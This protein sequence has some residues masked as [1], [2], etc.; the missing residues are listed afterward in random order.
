MS[1]EEIIIEVRKVI[2]AEV[3]YLKSVY[4]GQRASNYKANFPCVFIEPA[5]NPTVYGEGYKENTLGL[6]IV[7]AVYVQNPELQIIGNDTFK[8]VMDIEK[9]IKTAI[10]TEYPD[11][12]CKCLSFELN[13]IGY[14]VAYP[15]RSVS[16]EGKFKY[17]E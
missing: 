10:N 1:A 17:R 6:L 2:Q 12:G 15:V 5:D 11:L 4:L 14:D 3:T 7:G 13:T 16:I 8:G 9:D